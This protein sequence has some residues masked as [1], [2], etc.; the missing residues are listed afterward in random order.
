M[1]KSRFQLQKIAKKHRFLGDFRFIG[2]GSQRV[3]NVTAIA[4]LTS[5]PNTPGDRLRERCPL[6]RRRLAIPLPSL[7]RVW[8]ENNCRRPNASR[9][10]APGA[11]RRASRPFSASNATAAPRPP[12]S[13]RSANGS[14]T[15]RRMTLRRSRAPSFPPSASRTSASRA[16]GV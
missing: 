1:F 2:I 15:L 7:Y 14:S 3:A 5:P 9:G 4:L 6:A 10:A 16:A 13:S 12:A 11:Q 8:A